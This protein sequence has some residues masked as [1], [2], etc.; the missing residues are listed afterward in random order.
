MTRASGLEVKFRTQSPA[1]GS[2][3]AALDILA[4]PLV[5]LRCPPC[6]PGTPTGFVLSELHFQPTSVAPGC[7]CANR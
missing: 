7:L 3:L 1:G 6:H 2:R 4:L 5:L